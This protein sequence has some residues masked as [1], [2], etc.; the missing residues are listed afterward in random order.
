MSDSK[1]TRISTFGSRAT[2]VVSLTLSLLILGLLGLTVIAA[3]NITGN[4]RENLTVTVKVLPEAEAKAVNTLKQSF[5]KADYISSHTFTTADAILAQEV[6]LIGE[7]VAEL[8]DENP[9]SAEFELHLKPAYANSDSISMLTEKLTADPAVEEV[10][11]DT[12]VVDNVNRTLNKLTIILLSVAAAMLLISFVLINNTVS[13]SI[14]SR[15]FIIHTMKL[16][17][18]TPGFIRR[19]F[20]R[21]GIVNGLT[22]G[23]IATAVLAAVQFYLMRVD[24]DVARELPWSDAWI[25]FALVIIT[26]MLVCGIASWWATTRYL[27]R[28]YDSLYRK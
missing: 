8:L 7:D 14:Y 28:T 6:E 27:R 13:L 23:L 25:V 4:V 2:S 26:G 22:A 1:S 20:V 10:I 5:A 19:P 9:Y 3:R 17:G 21:A 15:R 18:A 11:T 24:S 16:V 12:I